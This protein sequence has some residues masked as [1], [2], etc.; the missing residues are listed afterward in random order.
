MNL[1]V[2]EDALMEELDQALDA[3]KPQVEAPNE[4]GEQ[5]T[6]AEEQ[7]RYVREGRRFVKEQAEK[8]AEQQTAP[9]PNAPQQQPPAQKAWK[10]T[11]YKDEYGAWDGLSEPF[12]NALREQERNASQA[13]E[14]HSTAAKA[15][16]PVS[17][18]I[19]PYQQQLAAQGIAPQQ[20]VS[21]LIN[22]DGYLRADPVK[23]LDWL[24]QSYLQCNIAELADWMATNG[25]QSEKIDPLQ[26]ELH[27]VKQQLARLQELPQQQARESTMREIQAWANDKPDFEAV[28][29]T[30][31]ALANQNPQASLDELYEEARWAHPEIRDRI[32]KERE[33][34]RLTELKGKRQMG[35]QSPR[36]GQTNG[37]ARNQRPTMS[38]EEEIAMHLDGGV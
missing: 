11:W 28:R 14:K 29:K 38:L 15:W 10:P 18:L 20:Y 13:I 31:G 19:E 4:G 36:G 25:H 7:A 5:E 22:A 34:K 2:D 12:R 6:A 17:K 23:A 24:C 32:L 21:N 37:Q 35:A 8:P 9:D 1:D 30:M 16:E 27:Q 33:D 26:Q 3:G